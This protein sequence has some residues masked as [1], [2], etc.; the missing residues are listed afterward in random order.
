MPNVPV[1]DERGHLAERLAT[2]YFRCRRERSCNKTSGRLR[3]SHRPQSLMTDR[4]DIDLRVCGG[5]DSSCRARYQNRRWEGIVPP[6]FPI[7][8]Y[9]CGMNRE[10]VQIENNYDLRRELE[11]QGF[12]PEKITPQYCTMRRDYADGVLKTS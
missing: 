8:A 12:W 6:F 3:R 2:R 9:T 10:I 1:F 5:L 7:Q 4:A 11:A